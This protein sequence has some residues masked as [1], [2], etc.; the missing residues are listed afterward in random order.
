M[1]FYNFKMFN[2][3]DDTI[4]DN[5]YMVVNE[6]RIVEIGVDK[7]CMNGIDLEGKYVMP[8][9]IDAHVHMLMDGSKDP[10]KT[11]TESNRT[12]K[13]ILAI[14]NLENTIKGGITFIRDVGG[15]DNIDIELKKYI[16][17]KKI[18]SP[19]VLVAGKVVTMTGGH[20][21]IIAREADGV[22]EVRKAVREQLKEGAD[23]I[24]VISSGGVLTPGV[25]INSV[26][27]DV[28]ELKIAV[29]EAHKAGKKICTHCHSR[30]GIINSIE[31]GV[32]SIEHATLICDEAI[33]MLK[34]SNIFIVPTFSALKNIVCG[35]EEKGIP[36]YV[37]D[38]ANNIGESHKN[39]FLK[40]YKAG[41]NIAMGTDAGTP[42]NMHGNNRNELVELVD[43]GMTNFDALKSG[44]IE[45]A[46]L[47]GIEKEY[48]SLE[49]GK[50]ADFLVLDNNPLIDI[51]SIHTLNRVYKN[52]VKI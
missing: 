2:G 8:G 51:K 28:D 44:T 9:L 32:D 43:N 13:V 11:I 52:G 5:S 34:D 50:Y 39:G 15:I 27:F 33:E 49:L 40:A 23:L 16:K 20:G 38:K 6:G 26:Q 7:D 3:V 30:Q 25:D 36:K 10:F 14:K 12:D 42:F 24:K 1:K 29:H 35:G 31:A 46:K 41:V 21:H 17:E 37:L 18:I 22:D 45:C 19:D 48:G 4:N 47:L